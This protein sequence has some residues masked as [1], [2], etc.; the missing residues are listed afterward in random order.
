MKGMYEVYCG[1]ERSLLLKKLL[2]GVQYNLRVKAV[3]AIGESSWSKISSFKTQPSVPST[4]DAPVVA[5]VTPNSVVLLWP[6]VSSNGADV[7]GY[8]VEMD[9]GEG[10]DLQMIARTHEPQFSTTKLR[11]GLMYRVRIRAENSEGFSQWSPVC[12][13]RTTSSP[14]SKPNPPRRL[15]ATTS[16]IVLAWSP[17]ELDGG[18]PISRYIVEMSPSTTCKATDDFSLGNWKIIYSGSQLKYTVRGLRA[19]FV[20]KV[21]VK[22]EN[23][24]GESSYSNEVEVHTASS[25]PE[26]P[27]G[28]RAVHRSQDSVQLRW[29]PPRHNGGSEIKSYKIEYRM[30]KRLEEEVETESESGMFQTGIECIECDTTIRDLEPG[31]CYEFRCVAENNLGLSPYSCSASAETK[32]GLPFAPEI[33][34]VVPGSNFGSLEVSW[35]RPYG[36]GAVVNSY[37]LQTKPCNSQ[38]SDG[39]AIKLSNSNESQCLASNNCSDRGCLQEIF[40]SDAAN[41]TQKKQSSEMT[42]NEGYTTVYQ[43]PACSCTVEDLIPDCNYMVRVQGGNSVGY[44]SW[45]REKL[46]KTGPAPPSNPQNLQIHQASEVALEVKWNPPRNSFGSRVSRYEL[47]YAHFSRGKR[48][49]LTW[50]PGYIGTELLALIIGLRPGQSYRIRVRASNECGWGEWSDEIIGDTAATLPGPPDPP[51]CSSK[52]SNTIRVSWNP[53][54]EINGAAIKQYELKMW[55]LSE[56]KSF[57]KFVYKGPDLTYKVSQLLPATEYG[58]SVRAV[59]AVGPGPFSNQGYGK[60]RQAPPLQPN[61]VSVKQLRDKSGVTVSWEHPSESAAHFGCSSFEIEAMCIKRTEPSCHHKLDSSN[62]SMKKSC[63]GRETEIELTDLV[64]GEYRIR[65]RGIGMNNSGHGTWSDPID[66]WISGFETMDNGVSLASIDREIVASNHPKN[67]SGNQ[68][69]SSVST[70]KGKLERNNARH[71]T[72]S[73]ISTKPQ[74]VSKT[75][76]AKPRPKTQSRIARLLNTSDKNLIRSFVLLIVSLAAVFFFIFETESGVD[77]AA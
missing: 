72:K 19:G 67:N 18:S 27:E 63:N 54:I 60:T 25:V 52:N 20:Y 21:R 14:P 43:G 38:T 5:S 74:T 50:N 56:E 7:S 2:P 17:P 34:S 32:P 6:P 73:G 13:V 64:P 68:M 40:D 58:F 70:T 47:Q 10:S 53:P 61:N 30:L 45:S 12:H 46:G 3:N 51:T 4:P 9:D 57:S 48:S 22:A 16:A 36:H 66:I 35:Q 8:Q 15:Q 29:N 42:G 39:Q 23:D 44:G 55:D 31:T 69:I 62:H 41:R 28:L 11:G 71:G 37:V 77:L 76:V 65:V 26:A 24:T 1:K 49:G 59:N 33:L 75:A